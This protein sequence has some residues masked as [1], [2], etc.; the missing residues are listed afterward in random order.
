MHSPLHQDVVPRRHRQRADVGDRRAHHQRARA[1]HHQERQRH[2]EVVV[3]PVR[4]DQ[5]RDRGQEGGG[6]YHHGGVDLGEPLYEQL[7]GGALRLRLLHKLDQARDGAI[8]RGA[9]SSHLKKPGLI[10]SASSH[11]IPGL[12]GD[13]Y[14][15]PR[16]RR[17]VYCRSSPRNHPVQGHL[18]A[19]PHD[20]DGADG[21]LLHLHHLPVEQLRPLGPELQNSTNGTP[22]LGGGLMLQPL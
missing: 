17:A 9:G 6:H 10:D 19:R 21:H 20:H 15:L 8:V 13:R 1:S 16:Q 14:A 11:L 4:V 12:L 5:P 18:R 7:G 2:V 22:G 3:G